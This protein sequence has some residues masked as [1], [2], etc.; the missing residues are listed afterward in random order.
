MDF[1]HDVMV[2][3]MVEVLC[4]FGRKGYIRLQ[5]VSWRKYARQVSKAYPKQLFLKDEP[6]LLNLNSYP[7]QVSLSERLEAI[8]KISQASPFEGFFPF[9]KNHQRTSMEIAMIN[10]IALIVAAY[11]FNQPEHKFKPKY[12]FNF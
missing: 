9:S 1:I 10:A 4:A 2:R 11:V 5:K 3:I 12:K 8:K 7:K 6:V